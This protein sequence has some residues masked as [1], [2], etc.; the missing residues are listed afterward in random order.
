MMQGGHACKI[1]VGVPVYNG[2]RYLTEALSG[3]ECQDIDGLEIVIS[4]NAS[5]DA[6]EEICREL[7]ARDPR[8]QYHRSDVNRGVSWNFNRTIELATG[9]LFMWN[10]A[11]DIAE[12]GHLSRCAEALRA[13]QGALI[14]FS[15]VS[16]I[17]EDG[18]V[19]GYPDDENLDFSSP[20]ARDRVATFLRR[21]AWQVVGYGG[22][23]RTSALRAAGGHPYYYGG[24]VVLGL[25]LAMRGPFAAVPERLFRSRR[26]DEQMSK[27]QG[28]DLA[29]QI[30][31]YDK[32]V[33]QRLSFPQWRLN[34]EM[35]AHVMHAP[36]S[37][38]DR[39]LCAATVTRFWTIRNWRFFPYDVKRNLMAAAGNN[40]GS[41]PTA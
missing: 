20:R 9:A 28:G 25:E 8:F 12:P 19:V 2:E 33:R 14:A 32:G 34:R 39:L 40:G 23:I 4:D 6:T 36:I 26:H 35:I 17:N 37:P 41:R 24:D 16:V 27:L 13:E 22:L 31:A 38:L 29:T 15:R 3:L 11:D 5:T 18:T 7:A 21:E 10:A 1:T 30:S